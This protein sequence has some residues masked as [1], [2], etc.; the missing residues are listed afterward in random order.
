MLTFLFLSKLSDSFDDFCSRASELADQSNGALLF[1][2]THNW[3]TPRTSNQCD[4]TSNG[5]QI[6]EDNSYD[7]LHSNNDDG[8]QEDE[9]QLL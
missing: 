9:W 6:R 1:T 7:M 3:S 8:M 2:V 5:D 4:M